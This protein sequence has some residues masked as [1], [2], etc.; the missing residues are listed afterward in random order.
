[1]QRVVVFLAAVM[2]I[3]NVSAAAPTFGESG[4]ACRHYPST[5][6]STDL[7]WASSTGFSNERS[8]VGL[9]INCPIAWTGSSI[10]NSTDVT[11]YYRD[12]NDDAGTGGIMCQ[13][14]AVEPDTDLWIG[15]QRWSCATAGGCSTNSAPTHK[16][17]T[18]GFLTV[19]GL[20]LDGSYVGY[21]VFCGIPDADTS[22][23]SGILA[24]SVGI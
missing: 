22:G 24:Y 17:T 7:V 15:A 6:S 23:M 8:D 16:N 10:I 18:P 9:Q 12:N 4:A 1:M 13:A 11:V 14:Q 21:A 3:P 20:D 5:G 19:E 2:V